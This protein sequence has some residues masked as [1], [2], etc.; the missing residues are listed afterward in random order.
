MKKP[1]N[2]DHKLP[3]PHRNGGWRYLTVLAL[4]LVFGSGATLKWAWGADRSVFWLVLVANVIM[5]SILVG[6]AAPWRRGL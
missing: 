4:A 5:V 3:L 1:V 6:I 2:I